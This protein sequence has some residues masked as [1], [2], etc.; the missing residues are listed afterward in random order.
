MIT[1]VEPDHVKMADATRKEKSTAKTGT[2]RFQA[3]ATASQDT[4]GRKTRLAIAR[5][6]R[7]IAAVD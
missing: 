6:L 7:M 4:A 3:K 1:T 5:I 2:G